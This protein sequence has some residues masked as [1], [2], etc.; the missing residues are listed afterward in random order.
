MFVMN[1]VS[2]LGRIDVIRRGGRSRFVDVG[3]QR[4]HMLDLPGTGSVPIVV[5]HGLGSSTSSFT[6]IL[7]GLRALGSRVLAADLPGAGFSPA[8]AQPLTLTEQ[9][10]LLVSLYKEEL[11]G[12]KAIWI[13]NSL[14]GAMAAFIA[15]HHPQM[16]QAMI[17]VA[18]AGA[19]VSQARF[20]AM[21]NG[22]RMKTTDDSRAFLN[23]LYHRPSRALTKLLAP[24]ILETFTS[25]T[26][27]IIL[28]GDR[29]G[30]HLDE[31]M[32]AG[33]QMPVM[34][35]WGKSEKILPY[36]GI[37][38]F[39]KHLPAHAV[40]EEVEGYS[41][42]PQLEVPD[43]LLRRFDRFLRFAPVPKPEGAPKVVPLPGHGGN[44]KPAA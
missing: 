7:P 18:P 44:A 25:P 19:K 17:L 38:Y 43:D 10:D 42:A 1:L 26:V 36:E 35:L 29:P 14:G 4:I 37:D 31:A 3:P 34:L 40:I 22:F 28:D 27:R 12:E 5:L 24:D 20:D 15:G 13:G 30:D 32:L 21:R 41:H 11:K 16:M 8:A 33:Y 9:V 39:R 23:R 2:H 6:R